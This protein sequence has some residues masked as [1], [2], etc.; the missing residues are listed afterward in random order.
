MAEFLALWKG[1]NS[2]FREKARKKIVILSFYTYP[3]INLFS[4]YISSFNTIMCVCSAECRPLESPPALHDL[5][6]YG[7]DES[8]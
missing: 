2:K 7:H 3:W 4:I 5:L 6:L 8:E 1:L